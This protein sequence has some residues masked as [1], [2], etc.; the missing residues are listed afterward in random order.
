M[1]ATEQNASFLLGRPRIHPKTPAYV[2]AG[3]AGANAALDLF[4]AALII[5]RLVAKANMNSF[6]HR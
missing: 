4:V 5:R 2:L 1:L 3:I 6:S